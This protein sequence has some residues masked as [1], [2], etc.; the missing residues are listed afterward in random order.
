[1]DHGS[2]ANV[3]EIQMDVH[4]GTHVDAPAHFVAD[5]LAVDC[6]DLEVLVGPAVVAEVLE[7]GS[8]GRKCLEAL[9]L[10][11]DVQRVLLRTTNGELWSCTDFEPDF[12]A[13]SA[14]GAAWLVDRGVQLVGIDY[15]SIQRYQDPPLTHRILLDAGVVILEGL[16]LRRVPPGD[17][18]LLCLP[19]ALAGAEAAPARA[20]LRPLEG[21]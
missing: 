9:N 21:G 17:Y 6:L 5:G 2:D 19:L 16:D 8:I 11:D 10:P 4:T 14:E 12:D 13:L 20:V 18:E 3:S 15:L 7:G 1:M